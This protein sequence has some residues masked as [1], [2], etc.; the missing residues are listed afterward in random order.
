MSDVSVLKQIV[1]E[2]RKKFT[3]TKDSL[4]T[5]PYCDPSEVLKEFLDNVNKSIEAVN[6]Q[7]RYF[8]GLVQATLSGKTRLLLEASIKHPIVFISFSK[9]NTAYWT[10]LLHSIS[11]NQTA[12]CTTFKERQFHNRIII[13]KVKIFILAYLDFFLLFK[14][15]FIEKNTSWLDV[16]RDIKVILFA[17]LLNG[18]NDLVSSSFK[19]RVSQINDLQLD[20]DHDGI[21]KK[22][23]GELQDALQQLGHPWIA[24]D[25]CH[26]PQ[27]HCK[28]IM[29]HSNYHEKPE[30][31]NMQSGL[32]TPLVF[33]WQ[34]YEQFQDTERVAPLGYPYQTT[35]NLFSVFR[36]IVE[37]LLILDSPIAT[38]FATTHYSCWQTILNDSLYSRD[39]PLIK[40]F[41]RLHR[42]SKNDVREILLKFYQID[43]TLL[44]EVS[45]DLL[46]IWEARPG[47]LFDIA[48]S[49]L[50]KK[51]SNL[52][53]LNEALR[54]AKA[55]ALD[56]VRR[57]FYNAAS[58][59]DMNIL[60]LIMVMYN[61]CTKDSKLIDDLVAA[62]IAIKTEDSAILCEKLVRDYIIDLLPSGKDNLDATL[63][64][65]I[66]TKYDDLA[67]RSVALQL[68][69]FRGSV[70]EL[71]TQRWPVLSKLSKNTLDHLDR[72]KFNFEV[73]LI[74]VT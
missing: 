19:L 10:S 33:A 6:Q 35:T 3:D 46:S 74:N 13:L 51:Y 38:I 61:G 39:K 5:S 29:F 24:F 73:S 50:H 45:N 53:D 66:G 43:E 37:E 52:K 30:V 56:V 4:F 23:N 44:S 16:D 26:V 63:V 72:F 12:K 41:S 70:K 2:K 42:L 71:L 68:L 47:F 31:R 55:S 65:Y 34:Q 7:K 9:G 21:K 40:P 36:W 1:E 60:Q 22:I 69:R 15:T 54:M 64:G 8:V 25:E 18:G 62:G 17:L 57:N 32:L 49:D 27:I 67:E 59:R 58:S 14:N 20:F 48:F 11:E 28:G